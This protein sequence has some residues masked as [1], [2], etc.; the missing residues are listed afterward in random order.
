MF[1][2]IKKRNGQV[3]AFDGSKITAAIAKAGKATGEFDEHAAKKMTL[4]VLSLAHEMQI[5]RSL[6]KLRKS[7][8]L[9]SAYLSIPPTSRRPRHIS[10]IG[11]STPI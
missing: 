8:T 3:V 7:K 10:F 11:S 2:H 1:T 6:R 9:W 4:R 5:S